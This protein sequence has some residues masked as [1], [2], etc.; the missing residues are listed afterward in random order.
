[1]SLQTHIKELTEGLVDLAVKAKTAVNYSDL[2]VQAKNIAFLSES[3]AKT[4]AEK[5]GCDHSRFRPTVFGW[6]EIECDICGRAGYYNGDEKKGSMVMDLK[7]NGYLSQHTPIIKAEAKDRNVLIL[8]KMKEVFQRFDGRKVSYIL[9]NRWLYCDPT[10]DGD[11]VCC[12]EGNEYSYWSTRELQKCG[13]LKKHSRLFD[14]FM[15]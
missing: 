4:L 7:N 11:E 12:V 9:E 8:R 10:E 15:C 3:M 13:A 5:D 6:G 2:A 1:M 14:C